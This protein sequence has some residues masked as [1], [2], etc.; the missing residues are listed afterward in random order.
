MPAK[1]AGTDQMTIE[2]FIAFTN[3][4]PDGEKW[5]LIDGEPI[6]SPSPTQWHQRIAINI[7]AALDA[8]KLASGA[9]WTATLGVGTEV[10][11]SPNSL[12]QPDVYVQEG[13]LLNTHVTDD[14]LVIFEILSK[15]NTKIDR[16]WRKRVYAS[17]P[18]CQHYVTIS[19]K[20]AEVIRH[21]RA[22]GWQG[23]TVK[24]LGA[25]L[26][27]PAIDVRIPLRNIYRW[28]SIGEP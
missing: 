19:T 15:S 8:A 23:E 10:P 27:L 7:A 21:D 3:A 11:I 17:V 25:D 28:T 24:G 26:S 2:E 16:A 1:L 5:E 6:L 18:N 14:A 20:S 13:E 12:P 4:R 22:D 9:S